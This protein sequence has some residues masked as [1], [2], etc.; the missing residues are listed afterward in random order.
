MCDVYLYL[1]FMYHLYYVRMYTRENVMTVKL[2]TISARDNSHFF[3]NCII[4]YVEL[5]ARQLCYCAS[6]KLF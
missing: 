2:L 6:C 4:K 1:Y 3:A 5:S